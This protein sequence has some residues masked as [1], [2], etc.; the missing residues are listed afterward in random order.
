MNM[1]LNE[2]GREGDNTSL[3]MAFEPWLVVGAEVLSINLIKPCSY[4]TSVS[5]L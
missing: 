4:E 2:H 1:T 5:C 3:Y